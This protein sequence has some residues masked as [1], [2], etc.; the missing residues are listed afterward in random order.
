MKSISSAVAIALALTGV[1]ARAEATSAAAAAPQASI[2]FMN[3]RATIREWQADREEGIWV[4]DLRRQWYYAKLMAP[5]QGLDFAVQVGFATRG[6]HTLDKFGE[7]IVPGR[8]RCPIQ[9]LTKSDAPPGRE[10]AKGSAADPQ[11]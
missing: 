10:S 9:S 2:P 8:D 1:V 3:Q 11:P 5:C 6:T 7:V 4:Q